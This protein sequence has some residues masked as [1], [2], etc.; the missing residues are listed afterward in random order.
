[1]TENGKISSQLMIFFN[2][3]TIL[4]THV[5]ELEKQQEK[6]EQYSRR[7]NVEIPGISDEV[8]DEN[9]EEKVMDICKEAVVDLKL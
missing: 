1:M 4:V 7:N 9:L 6:I 2:I 3:N 8:S 5:T